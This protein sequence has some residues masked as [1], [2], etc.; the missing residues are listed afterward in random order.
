MLKKIL[1]NKSYALLFIIILFYFVGNVV[2]YKINTPILVFGRD[3]SEHFMDIWRDFPLYNAP[4]IPLIMRFLFFC[5]GKECYDLLIILMNLC[6]FA[7]TVIYIY[8]ITR[9]LKDEE[10]FRIAILL[11]SMVPLIYMTSRIYGHQD[12]HIMAPVTF[13]MY[14]LFKTEYF[15]KL[16]YAVLFA[17]GFGI[18][19][20]LKDEALIF[21]SMPLLLISV[22]IFFLSEKLHRLRNLSAAIVII[23]LISF[24]H[25]YRLD[26]IK[27]IFFE[28][29][30]VRVY[31]KW[32][33]LN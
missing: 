9:F 29:I 6:F 8:K 2:W 21:I 27:K 31:K 12:Y 25:Y 19:V 4:V 20:M 14:Y 17:I 11:F 23:N 10:S 28:P 33:N 22:R 32:K 24:Y 18:S 26:I 30:T 7:V 5:F 1:T 13:T 15:K 3:T 16:N